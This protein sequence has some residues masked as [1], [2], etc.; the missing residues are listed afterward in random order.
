MI[1][2]QCWWPSLA[3]LIAELAGCSPARARELLTGGGVCLESAR[4]SGSSLNSD[5]TPVEIA[6]SAGRGGR[7]TRVLMDPAHWETDPV[8]RSCRARAACERFAR[9]LAPGLAGRLLRGVEQAWPDQA[10]IVEWLPSGCLWLGAAPGR[11]GLVA[12]VSARWGPPGDR[13]PRVFEWLETLGVVPGDALAAAARW[14][15]PASVSLAA[16][17]ELHARVYYRL[18]G[19]LLLA[20][21]ALPSLDQVAMTRFLAAV[22][23]DRPI[24]RAGLLLSVSGV[25]GAGALTGCKVDVCA[26]CASRGPAEWAALSGRLAADLG[27]PSPGISHLLL[28][29]QAEMAF[30]G[31]GFPEAGARQLNFYLKAPAQRRALVAA[32]A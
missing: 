20:D 30:I 6:V 1:A 5:G 26:H 23:G 16:A 27:L 2:E 32:H 4:A 14:G 19:P 10:A 12:Y 7:R 13:W 17:R 21:L 31:L 9:E 15:E 28:S 11:P 24:R 3:G 18:S 25:V 22:I 29:G 8:R